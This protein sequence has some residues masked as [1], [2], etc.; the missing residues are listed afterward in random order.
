MTTAIIGTGTIGTTIARHLVK[1]GERVLLAGRDDAKAEQVASE[2]GGSA[3]A[4]TVQKAIADADVIIFAVWLDAMK[5]LI[6]MHS[7][8]L[9]GKVVVDP[10]NP[11]KPAEGGKFARTLPDG[12]SAGKVISGL[13]P[14]GTHYVK[15]FGSLG[16]EAL[17]SSANRSPSRAAL[18]Y[19][20][21]DET[22]ARQIER[23]ISVAGFDPVKAGGVGDALRMEVF[24]DLHQ[25]GGLEGKVPTRDE[26]AA[27][28]ERGRV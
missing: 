17:A 28:V 26:A 7:R 24:G 14:P 3:R 6:A 21:D 8:G 4:T 18:L 27:A 1:G 16:A 10:S 11:I 25:F 20:T 5:E 13:L 9:R 22:A 19:A 12:V 23:L 15:A 2:L